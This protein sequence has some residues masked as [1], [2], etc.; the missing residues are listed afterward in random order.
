MHARGRAIRGPDITGSAGIDPKK[1][2]VSCA[3]EPRLRLG[4]LRL[5]RHDTACSSFG[6]QLRTSLDGTWFFIEFTPTHFLFDSAAFDQLPEQAAGYL[7]V[8]ALPKAAEH[9]YHELLHVQPSGL[10]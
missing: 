9:L 6:A 8:I 3:I 4:G 5:F 10:V 1:A 7:Y 2:E